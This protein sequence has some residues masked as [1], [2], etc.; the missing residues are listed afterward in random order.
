MFDSHP[1]TGKAAGSV[2]P[3]NS[4]LSLFFFQPEDEHPGTGSPAQRP[5]VG[6]NGSQDDAERRVHR[7]ESVQGAQTSWL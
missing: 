6:S 3:A 4:A 1:G 5:A 7:G 2:L